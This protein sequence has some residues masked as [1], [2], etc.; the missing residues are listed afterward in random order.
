MGVVVIR[1]TPLSLHR[2]DL[3]NNISLLLEKASWV[4]STFKASSLNIVNISTIVSVYIVEC[5][6]ETQTYKHIRVNACITQNPR[7]ARVHPT[8]RGE[9]NIQHLKLKIEALQKRL[10]LEALGLFF[11]FGGKG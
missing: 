4:I 5:E 1:L 9:N 2:R 10:N 8:R 3:A 11:L 6:H 7:I